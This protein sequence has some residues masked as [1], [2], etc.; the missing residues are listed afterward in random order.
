MGSRMLNE[1]NTIV[2]SENMF[3]FDGRKQSR[4]QVGKKLIPLSLMR[5]K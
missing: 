4:F 2:W 1:K 3:L 5:Y